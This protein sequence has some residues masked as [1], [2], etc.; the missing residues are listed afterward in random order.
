MHFKNFWKYYELQNYSWFDN[1]LI[2]A[3]IIKIVG[4]CHLFEDDNYKMMVKLMDNNGYENYKDNQNIEL[5]RFNIYTL[6]Y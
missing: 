6:N 2:L 1:I 5:T 3:S 4:H